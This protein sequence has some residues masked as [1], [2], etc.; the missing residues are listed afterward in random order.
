MITFIIIL[1]NFGSCW[2]KITIE[3]RVDNNL[4]FYSLFFVLELFSFILRL[5]LF[6]DYNFL[7]SFWFLKSQAAPT[8]WYQTIFW[9]LLETLDSGI[10][11]INTFEIFVQ[12]LHFWDQFWYI[13]T[14]CW[15]FLEGPTR[16]WSWSSVFPFDR[17]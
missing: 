16:L 13:N 17:S 2:L 9:S 11:S 10:I 6:L 1:F 7:A 4:G 15:N 12:F 8:F 5:Q 14:L 3:S